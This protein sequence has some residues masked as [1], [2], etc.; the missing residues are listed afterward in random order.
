MNQNLQAPEKSPENSA[1]RNLNLL[2]VDELAAVLKTPKSWVYGKSRETGPGALPRIKVGKYLRF[3]LSKV[4]D[5]LKKQQE[6][7]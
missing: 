4:M 2:T 3:E 5:W 6:V 7:E 1:V